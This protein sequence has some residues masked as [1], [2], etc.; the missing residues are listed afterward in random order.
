MQNINF[1]VIGTTHGTTKETK[2]FKNLTKYVETNNKSLWL[3]EGDSA[4]RKCTSLKNNKL[5]LITDSLFLNMFMRLPEHFDDNFKS[6]TLN[7]FINLLFTLKKNNIDINKIVNCNKLNSIYESIDNDINKN[8]YTNVKNSLNNL[9]N[10]YLDEKIKAIINYIVHTYIDYIDINF[11]ECVM[12]FLNNEDEICENLSLSY[13]REISMMNNTLLNIL[14]LKKN[15]PEI[16]ITVGSDHV[17]L[18]Y[19]FL[20]NTFEFNVSKIIL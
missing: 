3:C 15:V 11:R 9:S 1:Y 13:L 2:F 18:F 10:S 17:D 4:D 14:N 6:Y 12:K 16:I 20:K 19:N 5:H 7:K 8:S